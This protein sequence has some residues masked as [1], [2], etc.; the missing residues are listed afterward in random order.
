MASPPLEAGS[1]PHA[2]RPEVKFGWRVSLPGPYPTSPAPSAPMA[3]KH[4]ATRPSADLFLDAVNTR[5]HTLPVQHFSYSGVVLPPGRSAASQPA[6]PAHPRSSLCALEQRAATL[7][8]SAL[9]RV[10]PPDLTPSPLAAHRA[11]SFHYSLSTGGPSCTHSTY[12]TVQVE[13][14]H[15]PESVHPA[16]PPYIQDASPPASTASHRNHRAA[17]LND[18]SFKEGI[19]RAFLSGDQAATSSSSSSRAALQEMS[20]DIATAAHTSPSVLRSL[21]HSDSAAATAHGMTTATA[22]LAVREK[23]PRKRWKAPAPRVNC[24]CNKAERDVILYYPKAPSSFTLL[25]VMSV[26]NVLFPGDPAVRSTA[27]STAVPAAF[28]QPASTLSEDNQGSRN[29]LSFLEVI[30]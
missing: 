9:S 22:A 3:V 10:A 26:K 1:S 27:T 5:R 4:I 18:P 11:E 23:R 29:L 2:W 20:P 7:D 17:F 6:S 16:D 28:E 25:L 21:I 8:R 15:S 30:R 13:G 12:A 24:G 14:N 19:D